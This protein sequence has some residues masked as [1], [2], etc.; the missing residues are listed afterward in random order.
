MTEPG[1]AFR[2]MTRM[3]YKHLEILTTDELEN[4]RD[5]LK[6]VAEYDKTLGNDLL[7]GY[8]SKGKIEIVEQYIATLDK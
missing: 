5:A 8:T 6:V 3:A 7:H 1:E 4:L 2:E